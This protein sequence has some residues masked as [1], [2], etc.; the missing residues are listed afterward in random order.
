M[1]KYIPP[2]LRQKSKQIETPCVL[3]TLKDCTRDL[4]PYKI[5]LLTI[6]TFKCT[7]PNVWIESTHLA[8]GNAGNVYQAC[9]VNKF[10]PR[11][12]D[13]NCEF[14]VKIIEHKHR[15][16][17]D[18]PITR[19]TIQKEIDMQQ[20]FYKANLSPPIIEAFYCESTNKSYLL[21][22]PKQSTLASLC[23]ELAKRNNYCFKSSDAKEELNKIV[24]LLQSAIDLLNIA[25]SRHLFHGDSHMHN[26]MS[27]ATKRD[28]DDN[29]DF[30]LNTLSFIDF[31]ESK[32][33]YK[34]V[35]KESREDFDFLM[36]SLMDQPYG[37]KVF[38]HLDLGKF[39][40][41]FNE[42]YS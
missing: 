2:H 24:V 28:L 35:D 23:N 20:K 30:V 34:N 32:E 42:I 27:D 41:Y 9:C 6:N 11:L 1:S 17:Y 26:I 4:A 33:S 5:D 7:D 3:K 15:E 38:P 18:I 39:Q 40:D 13:E 22:L 25:H 29:F 10:N 12:V 16:R 21:T 37:D 8:D 19:D 14:I 36:R 31:G